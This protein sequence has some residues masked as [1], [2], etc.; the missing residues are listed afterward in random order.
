[1][2]DTQDVLVSTSSPSDAGASA[3]TVVPTPRCPIAVRPATARDLPFLD[4]LQKMHTHMVGW[5]PGKQIEGKIALGQVVVAQDDQDEPVG[6]CIAHD[7]YSGRDDVGII[8]QLNVL[9]LKQRNLIGATLIKSVFDRAAYGCRLFCCW[10]AQDIQANWF[11]ESCGFVPLAFR[12]G[13]AS[14][15]RVHIFWQRRVRADDTTTP[16]W[17]PSL[18]KAGAVR[19]DRIVLPIPPGTHWRD[20]KP[21]VLPGIE[22]KPELPKTL[23]GGA[24][25]RIRPEQPQY[26]AAQKAVMRRAQSKH[27]KGVPL[28][29][30]AVITRSGIKY[31]DRTDFVPEI[32]APDVFEQAKP[33]PQPKPRAKN[34][35]KLV[36]A[37]RELRDR[38][39]EQVNTTPLLPQGKY[40]VSRALP[41]ATA[42]V[43]V[44]PITPTAL[45]QLP[46]AA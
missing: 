31:V 3:L 45:K 2:A 42:T 38:W 12:T 9:P 17:F 14:K 15:Q 44:A 13:S 34:D 40:D 46:Q 37:A 5:M 39:L 32:D 27:L 26:S 18:T 43:N 36:A 28:G 23:P 19:E 4:A 25:I 20:A 29:K 22:V 7:Q 30:K 41:D 11:W 16:Y 10:C 21:I 24:P 1:M 35:P 8:Y 33:K 6:Y